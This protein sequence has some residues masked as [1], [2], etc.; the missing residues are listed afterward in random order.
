MSKIIDIIREADSEFQEKFHNAESLEDFYTVCKEIDS[1]IT[2]EEFRV[3]L[4]EISE[5]ELNLVAGGKMMDNKIG[6]KLAAFM[7]GGAT[8]FGAVIAATPRVGAYTNYGTF[9][10]YSQKEVDSVSDEFNELLENSQEA[11]KKL[12]NQDLVKS[13]TKE[14]DT[15]EENIQEAADFKLERSKYFHITSLIDS[16]KKVQKKIDNALSKEKESAEKRAAAE[17]QRKE[18]EEKERKIN[19]E[20]LEKRKQEVIKEQNNQFDMFKSN[21]QKILD[22]NVKQIESCIKN[23]QNP[24]IFNNDVTLLNNTA[25]QISSALGNVTMHS[26]LRKDDP[27]EFTRN[28]DNHFSKIKEQLGEFTNK[29]NNLIEE[30]VKVKKGFEKQIIEEAKD[31]FF[32]QLN[33]FE[34]QIADQFLILDISGKDRD[35]I[36]ELEREL[37]ENI[38]VLS[39]SVAEVNNLERKVFAEKEISLFKSKFDRLLAR[40]TSIVNRFLEARKKEQNLEDLHNFDRQIDLLREGKLKLSDVVGGYKSVTTRINSLIDQHKRAMETK[41]GVPSKGIILYGDPGTGK[42]SLVRAMAAA[43]DSDLVILKRRTEDGT[44]D[45][46]KEIASKFSQAKSLTSNGEKV[47]ILLVDEIDA[48]GAIRIPGETDKETVALLS[49]IDAL[50]PTDGV[51]IVATTNLLSSV[52]KAVKRGGRVEG[53]CEVTNP[54]ENDIKDIMKICISGYKL[55]EGMDAETF[56]NA[57]ISDF[58][59]KTGAEIKRA[60][61]LAIQHRMAESSVKLLSDV[62]LCKSDLK[63]AINE[64]GV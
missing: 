31:A 10:M 18:Q 29:T 45:M 27:A 51:V 48:L 2:P 37:L 44:L 46:T 58:R 25:E 34:K 12:S 32:N 63:K 60:V 15:L 16:I 33:D 19:E 41:K 55:E 14:L 13:F 17:A 1:S 52:D 9:H 53:I 36:Q 23:F 39:K 61:E 59:G 28:L 20:Y 26:A 50:K 6:K 5:D 24:E 54:S 7:L 49:E 21:L 35:T 42:T 22:N 62:V 38:K 30:V 43:N 64:F 40:K 11:V 57:F 8:L 3:Y 47:V 4:E 56:I